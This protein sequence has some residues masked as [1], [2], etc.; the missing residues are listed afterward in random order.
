MD[1]GLGKV[2]GFLSVV[3]VACLFAYKAWEGAGWWLVIVPVVIIGIAL[4]FL[5][6]IPAL[7]DQRIF[8]AAPSSG[9]MKIN[10]RTERINNRKH[11]LHIDVVMSKKDQ[12]ALKQ[13]GL[14]GHVLFQFPNPK[15][16]DVNLNYCNLTLL[17]VR[18]VDFPDTQSCDHAKTM[19]IEGLYALRSRLDQRQEHQ[20]L[21]ETTKE[22]FEI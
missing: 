2:I 19:L 7:K 14:E 13:S 16:P 18:H 3:G 1:E 17:H 6:G 11:R 10:I 8:N 4:F 15:F 21:P 12:L 9:P 20:R 5:M 22:S